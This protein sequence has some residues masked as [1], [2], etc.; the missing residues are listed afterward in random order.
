M[1]EESQVANDKDLNSSTASEIDKEF[2][3]STFTAKSIKKESVVKINKRLAY[4]IASTHAV[5]FLT[6]VWVIFGTDKLGLSLVLS[7]V[8]GSTGW[9]TSSLFEV[10][11]GAVAD[12]YGRK[13]SLILGLA[14]C[15]IGDLSLIAFESFTLL[16]AFQ[17]IAGVGYALQSGSLEGLLH[18]SFEAVGEPT[19][20]SK[21][22]S[23]MLFLVNFS[24]V[25][26]VPIGV[27]LYN[28]SPESSPSSYTFPYM[29]SVASFTISLIAASFLV[30]IH[31]VEMIK[32]KFVNENLAK[33]SARIGRQ[34]VET[35]K[36]MLIDRDV[37]RIM[38]L[39]GLYAFIGEGNWALYQYYFRE[40]DIGLTES[41][42]VYT[43][44]VFLM[45][46]GS[47][48]VAKIY[49][50]INVMWAMNFIIVLV[51]FN[52]VLMHL[53]LPIAAIGF[54]LSAFVGPMSLYLHD[55]AI[56]N[57]MKGNQK[58]TALS[59]A[60]MAYNIGAM[61]GVYGI[62]AVAQHIGVLNAQWYLVGYGVIVF[63]AMGAWCF[64]DGL[65]VRTEDARATGLETSFDDSAQLKP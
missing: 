10:P 17:V 41:G 44:L 57:R 5:G 43:V 64:R 34:M 65:A 25:L 13:I 58:T 15:A 14:C 49:K 59:I 62:G 54:V 1:Q 11:M 51:A 29:A 9:V 16:I 48:Y 21:L 23:R 6:P 7:L 38:I 47:L 8:L 45:A 12:K 46:M 28:L 3:E 40:R 19:Q 22:S 52:I 20:Y 56:Q 55:N 32:E 4:V 60:S 36:E 31:T 53:A 33:I 30:E 61:L 18:D 63:V 39:L 24:R 27:W 50:K 35:F 26:T 37:K 2:S 42:W